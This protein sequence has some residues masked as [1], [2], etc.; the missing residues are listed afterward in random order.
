MLFRCLRKESIEFSVP[1]WSIHKGHME[2]T[3]RTAG[4]IK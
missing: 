2:V 1:E 3:K 4:L